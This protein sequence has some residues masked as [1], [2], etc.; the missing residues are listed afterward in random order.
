M[1]PKLSSTVHTYKTLDG[2]AIHFRPFKVADEQTLLEAKESKDSELIINT[3]LDVLQGVVINQVDIKE[4]PSF[5]VEQLLLQARIVSIGNEISV[6][7]KCESCD[8]VNPVELDLREAKFIDKKLDKRVM[9][10]KDEAG[11]EVFVLMKYPTFKDLDTMKSKKEKNILRTCIDSISVGDMYIDMKDVTDKELDEWILGL[12]KD[13]VKSI[14]EFIKNMPK[15]HMRAEFTCRK[16]SHA[17][18]IEVE[19]FESFFT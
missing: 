8:D 18:K 11:K 1:L 13:K 5:E 6:G 14:Y 7:I 2:K 19:D 16:C 9:I 3:V 17:T 12:E 4:L 10:G 15:M